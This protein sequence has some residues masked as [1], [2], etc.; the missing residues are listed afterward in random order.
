MAKGSSRTSQ[1]TSPKSRT[2]RPSGVTLAVMFILAIVLAGAAI[3]GVI[4]AGG[5][6]SHWPNG[7]S[8]WMAT[9]IAQ[10]QKQVATGQAYNRTH[11]MVPVTPPTDAPTPTPFT[12]IF[13]SAMPG[14]TNFDVQNAYSGPAGG[15]RYTVYIGCVIN[16]Q[17]SEGLGDGGVLMYTDPD[18]NFVGRYIAPGHLSCLKAVSYS[19]VLLRLQ[20]NTG[21][22]IT[23][24]LLTRTF[25]Q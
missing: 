6:S 16:P 2:H 4:Q 22:T 20:S 11:T 14:H 25:V 12:G 21:Q 13:N 1:S 19:G 9:N 17:A 18:L 10:R 5:A 23:F 3:S 7:V 24:N 15:H 8:P